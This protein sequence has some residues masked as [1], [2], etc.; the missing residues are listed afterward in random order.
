[1]GMLDRFKRWIGIPARRD[2]STDNYAATFGAGN[3][4]GFAG[5][6]VSRLTASMNTWSA[7]VNLDLDA[8][9]IIMRARG[10]Q[11]AQS[12]EY[13]RRFLSLVATNI[14]GHGGPTLQV[15]AYKDLRN[16]DP[17]V[18]PALDKAANDA[19]EIHY[20]RWGKTC[21][22]GGRM[23]LPQ[24]LRVI[25]KSVARDGEAVIKFVVDKNLPYGLALQLLEADRLAETVN[26]MLPGGGAIRQ[27]VEIDSSGRPLALW[28]RTTHPGERYGAGGLQV[29][30]IPIEQIRHVFLPERAE[31]VRGYTWF[32]AIIMRAIQL[33]GF[34]DS[35]VIAARIGASKIA[36][37]ERAEEAPDATASLADSVTT[38][39]AGQQTG[40]TINAEAG[41]LFELPPGY[42]LNSWNPEYPHANFDSFVKA[43][44]RGIA[45]GLDV[46]THNLSGDMTD[47]N[48]SSARIAELAEREQWIILQDWFISAVCEPIFQK[49]LPIAM[50][51]GDITFDITGKA[52]PAEKLSKFINAASFKGRRWK[53]V[54][55]RNEAIADET[56]LANSL[57]SRT[58][59][60]AEEGR[61]FDDVLDEL[62]NERERLKAAGFPVDAATPASSS[63][64]DAAVTSSN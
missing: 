20:K 40:F 36:A 61:D 18:Q 45:S 35:A 39:A 31:Q 24:L 10:R 37:L 2:A 33:H 1:M 38:G 28:M 58:A 56:R 42:K 12:N 21:D 32:H 44:M 26:R 22:I 23:P 41:E 3:S 14:V 30:R 7:A 15:R 34:N 47:V 50:L 52:L 6:A 48:Y 16:P 43:A 57:T 9:L 29:E 53:W 55:P 60:A 8:S 46:A 49:W 11:L 64:P 59:L 4:L 54:D 25:A 62:I 17:K 19:I 63:V 27:G 13:G 5:G 51:R